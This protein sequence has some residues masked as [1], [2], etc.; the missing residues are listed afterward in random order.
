MDV[1]NE[2][3]TR[4]CSDGIAMVALRT[5]DG[6]IFAIEEHRPAN[7]CNDCATAGSGVTQPSSRQALD[8]HVRRAS[9]KRIGIMSRQRAGGGIGYACGRFAHFSKLLIEP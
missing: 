5:D 7:V 6:G 9:D 3:R 2:Y 1:A 8:D 4:T